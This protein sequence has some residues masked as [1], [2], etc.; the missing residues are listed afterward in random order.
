[1][2]AREEVSSMRI[3]KALTKLAAFV[4]IFALINEGLAYA[5]VPL[6]SPAAS[7]WNNYRAIEKN[8]LDT[9]FVGD[10]LS[11]E[12][13]DPAQFD[14]TCGTNSYNMGTNAQCYADS[15]QALETAIRDH[16]IKHCIFVFDYDFLN[17]GDERASRPQSAFA[18]AQA[19]GQP[20]G[21]KVAISCRYLLDKYYITL[22]DSVNYFMPWISNRVS[23]SWDAISANMAQKKTGELPVARDDN[24]VRTKKGFKGYLSTL[25]RNAA[26]R[27]SK[28]SWSKSQVS[29]YSLDQLDKLV[30][31]CKDN[32]IDLTV[33]TPP[34]TPTQVLSQGDGYFNRVQYMKDFFNERGVS[35]FDLNLAKPDLYTR[36][37]DHYK[38]WIH[39]NKT[40]AK[41]ITASV[42]RLWQMQQAGQDVDDLFYTP[43]QYQASI[44]EVD[45]VNLSLSSDDDGIHMKGRAWT[46]KDT[47]VEYQ[48]TAR[49]S[50]DDDYQVI[51]DWDTDPS[52]DWV[53]DEPGRWEIRV[54]AAAKD[55]D[56]P[57]VRK[58]ADWV[59]YWD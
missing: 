50:E 28:S 29:D 46:G 35:Y 37:E 2:P 18:R 23:G 48:F 49:Q 9:V 47:D 22:P 52:F 26:A 36:Q 5:L 15:V 43:S 51:R 33:Y 14:E 6:D 27:V 13:L 38:D 24:N 58:Y 53:P 30:T 3:I 8:T 32:N 11:Y 57:V 39:A 12:D 7:M 41:A 40:G 34:I 44:T 59:E 55:S 45:S 56:D 20:L 25:N 4:L 31:L 1:M 42:A 19:A 16:S 21:D 54:K 10:S 17:T